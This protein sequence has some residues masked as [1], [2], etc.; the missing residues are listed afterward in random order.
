VSQLRAFDVP[1]KQRRLIV[2]AGQTAHW[3]IDPSTKRVAGA[4]VTAEGERFGAVRSV[5][6]LVG[7]QRLEAIRGATIELCRDLLEHGRPG[8]VVVEEAVGYGKRPNPE[9]SYAVGATLCGLVAGAPFTH[10]EFVASAKWKLVVCGFGAI[11]KPPPT[12]R[13]EYEVL[14]WA[15]EQ[16]YEGSSWD[17]ADA[18]AI[19]DYARQVYALDERGAG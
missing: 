9:L 7:A 4:T 14:R 6:T 12:S 11:K 3:G 5:P 19:A 10:V 15:R 18:Y 17:V 16:G 2:R 13:E 1:R 8:V